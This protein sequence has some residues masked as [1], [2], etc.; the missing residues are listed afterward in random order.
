[1]TFVWFSLAA[2]CL[3]I[4]MW[5]FG[6]YQLSLAL[7]RRLHRFTPVPQATGREP[8]SFAVCLCAYN[9]AGCIEEKMQDLFRLREAC[10]GELDIHVYVDA[11]DDGTAEILRPYEGM[12]DLV[13]SPERRGKTH[14]MDLLIDRAR[15]EI[16]IFTDANVLVDHNAV[17]VL[18]RWFTDPTIG[19]VCSDLSYVNAQSSST[20]STGAAYWRFNEWS[21]ELE[22]S[23]GS[24]IGADGSLFA[25]R[26]S[27]HAPVPGGLMDDI[28]RSL[29][30]LCAGYRVVRAPELRAYEPHTT[31]AGDEFR[32]KVRIACE[33]THVH[34]TLW[35][36]LKK[37][38]AWHLYKYVAHRL[39][40]WLC[41]FFLLASAVFA[42][43][44]VA[45]LI[46]IL[47][48]AVLV[49][50]GGLGFFLA[51][52]LRVKI[53]DKL[54]NAVLAIAGASIGV[55]RAFRGERAVTWD[56]AP[57]SRPPMQPGRTS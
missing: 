4:A 1:M 2:I 42:L 13:V 6:P 48:T 57:S 49:V 39:L 26:R 25:I 33:C 9:E 30:I 27:L 16:I 44:F 50:A 46:G 32:R 38:D 40:R 34:F 22:T 31:I 12:I 11:A 14:G 36:R 29:W 10:G 19:C 55:F 23:T 53:V 21:K 3:V 5:P 18:R 45:S 15:A 47:P 54:W 37:L 7:A 8:A 17:S 35:S 52:R 41:G 56:V 20:A 43:A 24:V 51:L 28:Y